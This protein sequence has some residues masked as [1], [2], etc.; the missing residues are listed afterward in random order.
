MRRRRYARRPGRRRTIRRARTSRGRYTRGRGSRARIGRA[1][2]TVLSGVYRTFCVNAAVAGAGATAWSTGSN[3][4]YPETK[5]YYYELPS[6]TAPDSSPT[7]NCTAYNYL[8][9]PRWSD[10]LADANCGD[11]GYAA[12]R[13]LYDLSRIKKCTIILRPPLGLRSVFSEATTSGPSSF[14]E[15]HNLPSSEPNVSYFDFDY[16]STVGGPAIG[17][18]GD[19]SLQVSNKYGYKRHR[20]GRPIVRTIYPRYMQ[21]INSGISSL[22]SNPYTIPILRRGSPWLALNQSQYYMGSLA[23]CFAY[24]GSA[25]GTPYNQPQINY[26]IDTRIHIEFKM[27]LFG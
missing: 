21:G 8:I 19:L 7:S 18:D 11:P 17:M 6:Y 12:V 25:V 16:S 1:R 5:M 20:F 24:N 4:G 14:P 22:A 2:T 23:V 3:N 15:L 9:T 13:A 27:M 10:M 26:S